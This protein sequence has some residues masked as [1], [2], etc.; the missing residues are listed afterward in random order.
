MYKTLV[1]ACFMVL[2][3]LARSANAQVTGSTALQSTPLRFQ[4]S[5]VYHPPSYYP[6]RY[7]RLLLQ[8]G[9]TEFHVFRNAEIDLDSSLL[10]AAGWLGISRWLVV[11][12][13]FRSEAPADS[14]A[15]FDRRD[16]GFA[17]RRLPL[18]HG[19]SRLQ[20]LILLGA[21]YA[22]RPAD[23]VDHKDSALYYLQAARAESRL[24][25]ESAW[26]RQALC[27]MGKVCVQGD[28]LQQGNVLFNECIRECRK[29]GDRINE[30]KAWAWRGLY[31]RYTAATTYDR[32]ASLEK[33]RAIYRGIGDV[34]GE[35]NV[36]SN[37]GYL[38]VSDIKLKKGEEDFKEALRLEDSIC[39]AYTH[40]TT[41][42]IAMATSFQGRYGEP[43]GYALQTVKTAEALRDSLLWGAFYDRMTGLYDLLDDKAA[44]TVKWAQKA[45]DRFLVERGD[46][47][48]YVAVWPIIANRFKRH[49]SARAL[50]WAQDLAKQQPPRS[51]SAMERYH[52]MIGLCYETLKQYDS[53]EVH[54]LEA[55]KFTQ[56]LV[57]L[58]GTIFNAYADFQ[59][60]RLYFFMG[61]YY[62]AKEYFRRCL[63]AGDGAITISNSLNAYEALV[64]MDSILGDYRSLA[65]HLQ[66]YS[67]LERSNLNTQGQRQAEELAVRY[68][69][70]R[71]EQQIQLRDQRIAMLQQADELRQSSLR[72]TMLVQRMTIAGV[73][74]LLVIAL[75]LVRQN[76]QRKKMNRLIERQ[77]D[78]ITGKNEML[79]K[80][81]GEKE[82][83]LKEVNH[84]VKNNLQTVISLLETQGRYLQNEALEA[85]VSSKHRV[86]AMLLLHQKISNGENNNVI[87]MS[88][89]LDDIIQHLRE[90]FDDP[91]GVRWH[92]DIQPLRVRL[93]QAVPIALIVNESV[94]N[95]LKHAFPAGRHGVIAISFRH[96][97]DH[98]FLS[99]SDNGVGLG[100]SEEEAASETL[101]L[102][103]MK[104]LSRELRGHIRIFSDRG[105][106]VWVRFEA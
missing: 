36:L 2:L 46:A 89:Y 43:L 23:T 106:T 57:L 48:M 9:S 25:K 75:L 69:T 3:L 62:K 101:G 35:I 41:D 26:D 30:A 105:T 20:G 6:L 79:V 28:S 34:E 94:T 77:N 84:R 7:Q 4:P 56:K 97:K 15:W 42:D 31:T 99:V 80:V 102:G 87:E 10:H 1:V 83:L 71:M 59:L 93:R 21:Y 64:K 24:L 29:D 98:V 95:S 11:D 39:F 78:I 65:A 14:L 12:E 63:N 27:L 85:I 81:L 38:Y 19:Q 45:V 68:G 86:Y 88:G 67:N 66:A 103:L 49:E 96:E 51:I 55:A 44:E 37:T 50:A 58:H 40:Y 33:A 17:I 54:M 18:A 104:G 91:E 72:Q 22:F 90:S 82:W 47:F 53:A 60:G 32:I 100:R 61:K 76:R 8:L 16:P 73:V 74:V 5:P 52:F 13:G 92:L 70:E